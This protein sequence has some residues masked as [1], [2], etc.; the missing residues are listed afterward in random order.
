MNVR[1]IDVNLLFF[2]SLNEIA[3]WQNNRALII[4]P[5]S[6]GCVTCKNYSITLRPIIIIHNFLSDHKIIDL[7]ARLGSSLVRPGLNGRFGRINQLFFLSLEKIAIWQN[8][9]AP[10]ILPH[11]TGCVTCKIYSI[12]LKPI[13]NN[14]NFL[15]DRQIIN[16]SAW[17]GASLIRLI[18][19]AWMLDLLM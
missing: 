19:R 13:I 6:M 10:K 9:R 16:L 5:L 4:L 17:L 14:R 8:Y 12:T 1:F 2:L 7:S 3:H 18:S 11:S 15:N